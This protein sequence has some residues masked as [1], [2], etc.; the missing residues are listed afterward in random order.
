MKISIKLSTKKSYETNDGFPIVVY[1]SHNYKDR[2]WRTGYYSK[3]KQWNNKLARPNSKHPQYYQLLDFLLTLNKRIG[4]VLLIYNERQMPF[5]E[6]KEWIFNVNKDSFYDSAMAIFDKGYRGTD[7]SAMR[8]FNKFYPY[9]TFNNVSNKIVVDFRNALL[10]QGNKPS[11]VDSYIRSLKALWNKLSDKPNPFKGIV[12]E[13]PETIKTVATEEDLVKLT[14]VD[15]PNSDGFSGFCHYR[16]Y[17]LLMFY[18]GGIDPE[19]LAKLRYDRHLVA[20]RIIFNRDKGRSKT[21]CNNI[22]PEEA[23]EVLEI[24]KDSSF[25][26]FVPIY[27]ANNYKTFSGNFSRRMRDLSRKLQLSVEL[28]P[29]SARYTFIDRAQQLLIDE[30]ITAQIVGHKRRTTTSIYTND[31]PFK[32][33]DDAH[34]R[35][36]SV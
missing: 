28:R 6:I 10:K 17:W 25:P 8:R 36:I 18:L 1:I 15:L 32:L 22:L 35:I 3:I 31:F 12:T 11:G 14:Q 19:V 20:N 30:R 13:I 16:N 23:L 9:S 2:L 29:K 21:L 4:E 24:Y 5:P 33:Q 7:W 26:F 34:L 27:K